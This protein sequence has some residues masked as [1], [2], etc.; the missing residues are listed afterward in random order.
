MTDVALLPAATDSRHRLWRLAAIG[1]FLGVPLACGSVAV[2]AVMDGSAANQVADHADDTARAIVHQLDHKPQADHAADA[3]ALYLASSTASLARA[4]LQ[5]LAARLIEDAG[6]RVVE[7]RPS[8]DTTSDPAGGVSVEVALTISNGGLLDL[9]Y[10]AETGLPLLTV[11]RL[12]ASAG[13]DGGDL[14]VTLTLDGR[15][16]SAGP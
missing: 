3:A 14:Q 15:W 1:L 10:A 2:L 4:E 16:K 11:P 8:E 12:E 6:G 9:L 5:A 13:Q 7:I